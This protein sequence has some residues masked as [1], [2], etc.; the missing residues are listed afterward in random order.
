MELLEVA[1]K[2]IQSLSNE[3]FAI[4][5]K[6]GFGA[7][8]S[9]VLLGVNIYKDLDTLLREKRLK[10]LTDEEKAIGDKPAV[11]KGRDLEDLVLKKAEEVLGIPLEKPKDMYRFREH[12]ALTVNFDGVGVEDGVKIPVEAKIV[13]RWG[14]KYYNKDISPHISN[15]INMTSRHA[16]IDGHIKFMADQFGIPPYYYT[17]VQQEIAAL[18]APY[19]Y[20]AALFDHTWDFKLYKI[21]R[22]DFVIAKL[23]V[24]AEE[25]Y[26]KI[27]ELQ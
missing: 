15:L 17:Q 11:K 5:R 6:D 8:D 22:D 4:L 26:P 24:L 16:S 1:V 9:S 12:P 3:E 19:G 23:Y 21:L 7:S 14:E 10:F 2:D 27:K 25:H 13:T 18:G 20:L